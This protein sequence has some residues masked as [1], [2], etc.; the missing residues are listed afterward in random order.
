MGKININDFKLLLISEGAEAIKKVLKSYGYHSFQGNDN[1]EKLIFGFCDGNNQS[2]TVL[3]LD[4]KLRVTAYTRKDKGI[5][6]IIDLLVYNKMQ[7]IPVAIQNCL[8]ILGFEGGKESDMTWI[9]TLKNTRGTHTE[10]EELLDELDESILDS[11]D[12][13]GNWMFANDGISLEQM[14]NFEIGMDSLDG[15]IT[16]PIRDEQGRLV[17]VKGRHLEIIS[18]KK[19]SYPHKCKKTQVLYGLNKS[20]ENI[21]KSGKVFVVEAEKGVMQLF[22]NKIRNCVSIG[23]HDISYP[24]VSKLERLGVEV[25]VCFDQDVGRKEDGSFDKSKKGCWYSLL[26]K[27]SKDTK[28]SIM[29]DSSGLLKDKESPTDNISVIKEMYKN[30]IKLSGKRED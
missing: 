5:S 7:S 30:R 16:I 15:I 14:E 27:F 24:Q 12:K 25:I 20:R 26:K 6:D 10:E 4:E 2:S 23:G 8:S 13:I 17:G 22:S 29:F 11:Y 21:I 18:G 1:S 9:S 28:V 3:Y 19:Y